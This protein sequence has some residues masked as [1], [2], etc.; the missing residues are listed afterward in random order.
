M[1]NC[2]AGE[3]QTEAAENQL[4]RKL[5]WQSR[6]L[7]NLT[8]FYITLQQTDDYDGDGRSV[9]P[10]LLGVVLASDQNKEIMK[11]AYVALKAIYVGW[12]DC[13]GNIWC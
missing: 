10:L 4:I 8:P 11:N 9:T 13:L 1:F 3:K 6:N 2:V 7:T 12:M 5:S